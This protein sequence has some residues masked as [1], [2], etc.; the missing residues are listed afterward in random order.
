M[1]TPR[2]SARRASGSTTT[3]VELPSPATSPRSRPTLSGLRATAP[4][5]STPF[6][7]ISRAM[8]EPMAPTPYTIARIGMG[9]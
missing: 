2:S 7:S 5:I 1:S 6:S 8:I 4:T 9:Y 3:P